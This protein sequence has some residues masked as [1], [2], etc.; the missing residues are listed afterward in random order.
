M[1]GVKDLDAE[2]GVAAFPTRGEEGGDT[3]IAE[4]NALERRLVL[5][6]DMIVLPMLCK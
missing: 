1:E 6:L 3:S 2:I 5:K 4:R